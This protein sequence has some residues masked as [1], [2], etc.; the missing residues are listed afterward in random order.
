MLVCFYK[1]L[2]LCK[3]KYFNKKISYNK[4]Y[5]KL[6]K[7]RNNLKLNSYACNY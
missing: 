5:Y 1:K 3:R 4:K 6:D 7:V 2:Y